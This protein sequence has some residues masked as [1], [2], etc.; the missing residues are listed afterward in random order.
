M[1]QANELSGAA[2][3]G[4]F[5]RLEVQTPQGRVVC[6]ARAHRRLWV[7]SSSKLQLP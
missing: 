7:R 2:S 6:Q 5:D 3:V 1:Q 4:R